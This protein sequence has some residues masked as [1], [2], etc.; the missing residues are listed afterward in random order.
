V[1]SYEVPV[2][3]SALLNGY[4]PFDTEYAVGMDVLASLKAFLDGNWTIF[5]YGDW[6]TEHGGTVYLDPSDNKWRATPWSPGGET[7]CK[8]S[9]PPNGVKPSGSYHNHTKRSWW[10]APVLNPTTPTW[11]SDYAYGDVFLLGSDG[12]FNFVGVFANPAFPSR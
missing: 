10:E 6:H 11:P 4:D 12:S 2:Q 1:R 7:S 3:Q 5:S 9:M 8:P